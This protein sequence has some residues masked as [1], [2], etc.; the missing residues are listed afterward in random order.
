MFRPP[1]IVV[2]ALGLAACEPLLDLRDDYV[3]VEQGGN[4]GSPHGGQA[5]VTTG[6][7][8]TAGPGG[9]GGAQCNVLRFDSD[10]WVDILPDDMGTWTAQ[11]LEAWVAWN[12]DQTSQTLVR[13]KCGALLASIDGVSVEFDPQCDGT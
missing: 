10:D 8:A 13:T 9:S 3:L 4:G 12:V 7:A 1:L 6:A 11:T 5:S 2:V